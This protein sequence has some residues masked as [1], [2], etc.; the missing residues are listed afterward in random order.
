MKIYPLSLRA[1]LARA[2]SFEPMT[3]AEMDA[4]VADIHVSLDRMAS[5][6]ADG[7]PYRMVGA[8]RGVLEAQ[9]EQG[10]VW[11]ELGG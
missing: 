6:R 3:R 5:A 4:L 2:D 10:R 9:G 1:A 8:D 7:G 11:A